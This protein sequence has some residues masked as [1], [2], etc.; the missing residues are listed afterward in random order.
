MIPWY[1]QLF[2]AHVYT[3]PL[4]ESAV[5]HVVYSTLGTVINHMISLCCVI[6]LCLLC[7]LMYCQSNVLHNTN[8]LTAVCMGVVTEVSSCTDKYTVS[9]WMGVVKFKA[10]LGG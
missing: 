3:I 1:S 2:V 4:I 5:I 6:M 9:A 7:L 10:S 8:A